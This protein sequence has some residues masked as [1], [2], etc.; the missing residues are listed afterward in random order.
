M[1]LIGETYQND[2]LAATAV[3][4]K[5]GKTKIKGYHIYNP[6]NA[7]AYIQ[8]FDAA[9]ASDVNV[10]TTVHKA[11]IGIPRGGGQQTVIQTVRGLCNMKFTLGLV[12][13]CTSGVATNGDPNAAN[14]VTIEIS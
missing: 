11:A 9:A 1:A 12:I 14:I 10:G 13:A 2:A 3:L 7:A 6:G 4:V 5:T 8:F